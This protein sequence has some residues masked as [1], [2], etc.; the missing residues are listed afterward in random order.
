MFLR[1]RRAAC[2]RV[3]L[4]PLRRQDCLRYNGI[5]VKLTLLHSQEWLCYRDRN[6]SSGFVA[7]WPET[8]RF[9]VAVSRCE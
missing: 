5:A 9:E 3:V 6:Y 8:E 7:R 4:T 1:L 2:A